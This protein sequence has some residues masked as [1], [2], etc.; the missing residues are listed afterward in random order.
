[1]NQIVLGK[2]GICE[3][4]I[5]T[6]F[7]FLSMLALLGCTST[8]SALEDGDAPKDATSVVRFFA[9]S[10]ANPDW[11]ARKISI[12][13][14][15]PMELTISNEAFLDE[16]DVTRARVIEAVGGFAIAIEFT[17]HGLMALNM[18]TSTLRGRRV[19]IYARWNEK[20]VAVERWLAAPIISRPI[21]TG[22]I[23]FT[24]DC[25]R[26]EAD[27]FVLGLNQVAIKLENQ[28]KPKKK[29]KNSEEDK[30]FDRFQPKKK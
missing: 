20:K 3:K 19:A 9:E 4:V 7:T 12:I 28:E 14:N 30:D 5:N 16:R 15:A 1:M 8:K 11:R 6:F 10:N 25:T 24:P 29:K 23:A 21:E 13:R 18:E 2:M 22:V 27:L 26:E 17:S